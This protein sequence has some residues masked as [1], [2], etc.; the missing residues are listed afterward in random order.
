MAWR[1]SRKSRGKLLLFIASISLGVG[2]LVGITS[3]R[4]NLMDE[5]DGQAKNLLGADVSVRGKTELPD[6]LFF[7]MSRLSKDES[8]E[9]YFASMVRFP[10][11]DGTRL[12]QIRALE[13][14]YPYYGCL[15]YTS[16]SPRDLSTSRMPSSA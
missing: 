15:L 5:I 16:P 7:Q 10:S 4:E 1:D 13:G 2:A 11:T 12:V 3:F 9:V 6:S 14:N 8:N